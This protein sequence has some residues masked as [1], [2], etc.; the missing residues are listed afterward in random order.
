MERTV[1]LGHTDKSINNNNKEEVEGRSPF[2][3]LYKC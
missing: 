3:F 2:A 1:G